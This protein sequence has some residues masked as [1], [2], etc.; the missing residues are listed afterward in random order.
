MIFKIF[1]LGDGG[2]PLVCPVNGKPGHYYQAGI[3]AWGIGELNIKLNILFYL[4][5]NS[6]FLLKV[7]VKMEHLVFM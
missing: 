3:V 1:F 2:S 7:A 4:D 5:Y 6:F